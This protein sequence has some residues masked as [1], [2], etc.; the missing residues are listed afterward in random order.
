ME[1]MHN[2]SDLLTEIEVIKEQID[3]TERELNYWYGIDLQKQKGIP[4][5]GWGGM[6]Y[7][8]MTAL[9]QGEKKMT[10]LSKL[11]ERLEQ[12]EEIKQRI[13]TLLNKFE[14]LEYQIAY[15]RIVEHK[16]HQEIADE[17]GYSHQYIKEKWAKRK[18]ELAV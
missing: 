4:L 9:H 17:L 7:G 11:Q 8:T 6:K 18:K 13:E 15:K 5:S 1:I 10:S 14:G 3:L 16:T 12:L 2:Y